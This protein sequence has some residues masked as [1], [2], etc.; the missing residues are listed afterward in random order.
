ME[1]PY[2]TPVRGQY[3]NPGLPGPK[4]CVLHHSALCP[5]V[6]QDMCS[7]IRLFSLTVGS[8]WAAVWPHFRPCSQPPAL[9]YLFPK[10]LEVNLFS[11]SPLICIM[12]PIKWSKS[13]LVTS[14]LLLTGRAGLGGSGQNHS[15]AGAL[16]IH[17]SGKVGR[18]TGRKL[19]RREGGRWGRRRL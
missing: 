9:Y 14:A 13:I 7:P 16:E 18:G 10:L 19:T 8:S 1:S 2:N 11:L 12:E 5:D 15:R 17:S 3:L 6:H 4:A